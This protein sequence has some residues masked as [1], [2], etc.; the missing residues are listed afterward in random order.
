MH[1]QEELGGW[2]PRVGCEDKA[3]SNLTAEGP[4]AWWEA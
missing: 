1:E 4:I 3:A 2:E